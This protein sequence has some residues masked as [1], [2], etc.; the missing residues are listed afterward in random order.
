MKF[1]ADECC[2]ISMVNILRE[3]DH[4]ILSIQEEAPGISDEELLR[5]ANSEKRIIITEDKDFGELVYRFKKT[6]FGIILLR[7]R[8]E[9]SQYKYFVMSQLA[10]KHGSKLKNNLV[11]V[12]SEKIR[13]R[14]LKI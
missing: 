7:F 14:P 6:S 2:E 4:D 5:I 8:P 1:L 13:I 11:I 9:E 3:Q 12:T 10:K